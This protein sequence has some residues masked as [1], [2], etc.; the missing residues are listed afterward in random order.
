MGHLI[1]VFYE[2]KGNGLYENLTNTSSTYG[3]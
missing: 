2:I 3:L 1:T